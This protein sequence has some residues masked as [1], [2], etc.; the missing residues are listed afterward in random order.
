MNNGEET[1]ESNN[2]DPEPVLDLALIGEL[3][4]WRLVR[5]GLG[6]MYWGLLVA[7]ASG[8]VLFPCGLAAI[9]GVAHL[10]TQVTMMAMYV[11]SGLF[12]LSLLVS[13]LGQFLCCAAPEESGGRGHAIRS[14]GFLIS[15]T[16]VIGALLVLSRTQWAERILFH[17]RPH[18]LDVLLFLAGAL[19]LAWYVA[20]HISFVLFL[21]ALAGYF[22]NSRLA[23]RALNYLVAYGMFSALFVMTAWCFFAEYGHSL[24]CYLAL[25]LLASGLTT[26]VLNF[27]LIGQTHDAIADALRRAGE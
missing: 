12:A 20:G 2:D 3:R 15:L 13:C 27:I 4:G 18:D 26:L 5:L 11:P 9:L 7:S 6:M 19:I 17:V 14:V 23:D 25:F 21:R 10:N 8:V 22:R 1:E 24:E 16:A